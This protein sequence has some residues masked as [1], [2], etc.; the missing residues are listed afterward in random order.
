MIVNPADVVQKGYIQGVDPKN[1]GPNSIDLRIGIV[2]QIDG[3]IT[4]F[5]DGN[6]MLPTYTKSVPYPVPR[7][8]GSSVLCYSL[9]P[10]HLFQIE[11]M[12]TVRLP[13]DLCAM[14]V[15]RSSL[16]KSGASGEAGLYDSGYSGGTRMTVGV[17]FASII[18]VGAPVAQMIFF[19]ADSY[20]MYDGYY[21]DSNWRESHE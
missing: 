12:E 9:F 19:R 15:L 21:T 2:Y 3:G 16:F 4:L 8:D 11:F 6:R 1:I 18:E 10:Q 7:E 5:A 14:T 17:K 20:K 13:R